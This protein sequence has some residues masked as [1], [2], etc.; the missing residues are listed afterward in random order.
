MRI[1]DLGANSFGL[2]YSV[3]SKANVSD[4]E[5]GLGLEGTGRQTTIAFNGPVYG[6]G[7][8]WTVGNQGANFIA[9][10]SWTVEL[11]FEGGATSGV[12]SL[13]YD[14]TVI[15]DFVS[16]GWFGWRS[17]AAITKVIIT[18]NY[19]AMDG[20]QVETIP[21]PEPSTFIAG[22][23]LALPFGVQGFRYL[24]NRKRAV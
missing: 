2:E 3:N 11:L 15:D 18:G 10:K 12:M 6:F 4:G 22:A 23:L 5:R 1:Y 21:V 19:V 24:R 7:S 8:Y 16:L 14:A 17:D 9:T 20:L 13:N